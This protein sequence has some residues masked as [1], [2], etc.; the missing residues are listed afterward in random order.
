MDAQTAVTGKSISVDEV[1]KGLLPRAARR[2]AACGASAREGE[3]YL[4]RVSERWQKEAF[5]AEPGYKMTVAR[6]Y[7][8][9]KDALADEAVTRIYVP[10]NSS[11]GWEQASL[12]CRRG[13]FEKTV[14]FED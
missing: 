13:A 11:V 7:F 1:A 14:F 8:E 10:K 4:Y 3:T 12:I 6:S 9:L 5:L 2:K